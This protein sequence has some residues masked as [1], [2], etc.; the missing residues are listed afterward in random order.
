MSPFT[1]SIRVR[2][3]S[4]LRPSMPTS[5]CAAASA[6][7]RPSSEW[8]DKQ[9]PMRG[10]IDASHCDAGVRVPSFLYHP[11]VAGLPRVA[12]R[13]VLHP[14]AT[15]PCWRCRSTAQPSGRGRPRVLE[16]LRTPSGRATVQ[17]RFEAR[18]RRR[19]GR[20]C[21]N[22]NC[23][24]RAGGRRSRRPPVRVG[25]GRVDD[26]KGAAP[27]RRA[28]CFAVQGS[29]WRPASPRVRGTD[30]Q[31]AA[32]TSRHR[33]ARNG[34]RTREVGSAP[35][36]A[37]TGV[38]ERVRIV[39]DRPH[40]SVVGRHSRAG[41]QPVRGHAQFVRRSGGGFAFG[42]CAELEV[43]LDRLVGSPE[44]RA[45]GARPDFVDGHYRWRM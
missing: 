24:R 6:S 45:S 40:G 44:L 7:A 22:R 30:R 17:D 1:A 11:T 18:G 14:A 9:G 5:S 4:R 43:E 8:I 37:G 35:R 34:R 3:F 2:A 39:L 38:T 10:L 26:G 25:L 33:D 27:A 32:R 28:E 20:R 36:C 23:G 16:R 15:N 31:R 12:D 19:V 29:A 21:G 41:E 13:A 42:S